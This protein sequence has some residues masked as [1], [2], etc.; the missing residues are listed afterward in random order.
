MLSILIPTY[1]HTCYTLVA[2]LQRQAE[3]LDIP[4]EIIVVEDGSRD[5]VSM[6]ANLKIADLPHCRYIR[7]KE[8]V[9]RA[10]I[11][12]FLMQESEGELLLF[13]D[14]D[15]QVINDDFLKRYVDA[16][17]CHDV[18]CGGVTHPDKWNNPDSMLRWRYEKNYERKHGNVGEQFRSFSFMINRRVADKARFDERYQMYGYEDVQFGKDLQTAGFKVHSIDNPLLNTDIETNP[19][20]LHKTEEALQMAFQFRKDIGDRITI[21]RIHDRYRFL[22][23]LLKCFYRLF[24]PL[25]R[26]N[27]LSANPSLLLFNLYKL[28]HYSC[29]N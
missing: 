25:L 21:V 17:K 6:I 11:R 27:L 12:N 22:S 19:V 29:L 24:A 13:V 15:A 28:G 26:R 3:G 2:D 18:V 4:Y 16:A 7:C 8:N 20:F 5:S 10:A 23:P 1:N 9:G 14:S